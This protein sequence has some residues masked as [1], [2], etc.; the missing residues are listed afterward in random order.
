ML[1]RVGALVLA[2]AMVVGSLVVRSRID[3]SRTTARL[4]CA[5]E[6]AAA[7]QAIGH[8]IKVTVEPAGVTADRL[9][10][11]DPGADPGLD[12]WLTPG[13]WPQIVDQQRAAANQPPLFVVSRPLASTRLAVVASPKRAA[14]CPAPQQ[15]DCFEGLMA[16][17]PDKADIPDPAREATG[18][19]VLSA[20]AP[21]SIEDA[22]VQQR[23]PALQRVR[24]LAGDD[25][26]SNVLTTKGA[27][28]NLVAA[29]DA[30][31]APVI[32]QAADRTA[33]TKLY[34]QP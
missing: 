21:G 11:L 1:A 27:D 26:V 9:V 5:T 31:L 25:A 15:W 6:L 22:A 18:P 29:L 28:L 7:C 32:D 3:R 23:L 14:E 4:T 10:V 2:V 20:V 24:T 13:P 33:V 8:G 19:L 34:P 17:S 30:V 16:A 12:G